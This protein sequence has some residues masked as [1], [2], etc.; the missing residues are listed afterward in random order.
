MLGEAIGHLRAAAPSLRVQMFSKFVDQITRATF[1]QWNATNVN[2]L[3][4]VVFAGEGGEVLA[5]DAAGNMFRGLWR[6]GET[7][8]FRGLRSRLSSPGYGGYEYGAKH[9]S[10]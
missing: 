9:S 5:F 4:G 6:I 7:F 3:N 2:A 1:G 8:V 10:Q